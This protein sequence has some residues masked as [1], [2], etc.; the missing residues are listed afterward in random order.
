MHRK[1]GLQVCVASVQDCVL[2]A[3]AY[4]RLKHIVDALGHLLLLQKLTV[5]VNPDSVFAA[6][7]R[8]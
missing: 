6:R 2:H 3:Q 8:W 5:L 4:I 7:C 1:V